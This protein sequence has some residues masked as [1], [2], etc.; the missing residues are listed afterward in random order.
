VYEPLAFLEAEEASVGCAWHLS[1]EANADDLT[2]VPSVGF[3]VGGRP[4]GSF[5][6]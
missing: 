4:R 6:K 2:V 1:P 5:P 3:F